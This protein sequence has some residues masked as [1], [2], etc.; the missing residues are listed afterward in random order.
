MCPVRARAHRAMDDP[1]LDGA[2]VP[3]VFGWLVSAQEVND[4]YAEVSWPNDQ[5]PEGRGGVIVPSNQQPVPRRPDPVHPNKT[6]GPGLAWIKSSTY[7]TLLMWLLTLVFGWCTLGCNPSDRQSAHATK[8]PMSTYVVAALAPT[9]AVYAEWKALQY[10]WRPFLEIRGFPVLLVCPVSITVYALIMLSMTFANIL[11]LFVF[12]L[13]AIQ[14]TEDALCRGMGESLP[15]Q[16]EWDFAWVATWMQSL[17]QSEVF[18]YSHSAASFWS[19]YLNI[20]NCYRICVLLLILPFP[21][22]VLVS[23]WRA[24]ANVGVDAAC[25]A[26]Y[27][28][29]GGTWMWPE[30]RI[31]SLAHELWDCLRAPVARTAEFFCRRPRGHWGQYGKR[32]CPSMGG[33]WDMTFFNGAAASLAS[34]VGFAALRDMTCALPRFEL[35]R[36]LDTVLDAER[37]VVIDSAQMSNI[38]RR[39]ILDLEGT[40]RSIRNHTL[41]RAGL[42]LN[43]QVSQF[44]LHRVV[45]L[46]AI[47][48][49]RMDTLSLVSISLTLLTTLMFDPFQLL[50]TW[51]DV[52]R[53]RKVTR[54]F[55]EGQGA[56][57]MN[58]RQRAQFEKDRRTIFNHMIGT[59]VLALISYPL[60]VYA[61]VKL[62]RTLFTCPGQGWNWDKCVQIPWECHRKPTDFQVWS[63]IMCATG[64]LP[65]ECED[66]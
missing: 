29:I 57:L 53:V 49:I 39:M 3:R 1:L 30:Q 33:M 18:G 4:I 13:S 22:A 7:F 5:I 56:P 41:T 60:I 37:L 46:K 48:T 32:L 10:G 28:N 11:S 12:A 63:C 62:H 27:R 6:M 45:M 58:P 23:N 15:R 38:Q 8:Y 59:L 55:L 64:S 61:V 65:D 42:I 31:Q 50:R 16:R 44:M 52:A 51:R 26:T 54:R 34:A 9:Y 17:P 20:K 19:K 35:T 2:P 43:L 47:G 14:A 40:M 24:A 25:K 21:R 36:L 66:A